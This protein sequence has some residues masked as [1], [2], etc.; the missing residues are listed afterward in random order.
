M[1][2]DC[3]S[4]LR[5]RNAVFVRCYNHSFRVLN[6]NALW[7]R[8]AS[9]WVKV[10]LQAAGKCPELFH[11]NV[12]QVYAECSASF[13]SQISISHASNGFLLGLYL[14]YTIK[15]CFAVRKIPLRTFQMS[16]SLRFIAS[17][18]R[19]GV[20]GYAAQLRQQDSQRSSMHQHS[21][22]PS[23][24]HCP[25]GGYGNANTNHQHQA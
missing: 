9:R 15:L 6:F 14:V 20:G 10:K 5:C 18:I 25:C 8:L 16:N 17:L 21:H 12:P 4:H 3:V 13:L 11:Y 7:C 22:R 2:L 19:D 23:G 24:P 1:L